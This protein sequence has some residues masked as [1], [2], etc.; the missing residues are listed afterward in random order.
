MIQ[1]DASKNLTDLQ[2]LEIVARYING[3]LEQQQRLEENNKR[4]NDYTERL[5]KLNNLKTV[6]QQKGNPSLNEK[7]GMNPETKLGKQILY[8]IDNV[9]ELCSDKIEAYT[10]SNDARIE[11]DTWLV[12][13]VF[14]GVYEYFSKNKANLPRDI[15][16]R[17][18][19]NLENKITSMKARLSKKLYFKY[20]DFDDDR[21]GL[22]WDKL[23]R[24]LPNSIYASHRLCQMFSRS[25][26]CGKEKQPFEDI[27]N[28]LIVAFN[29]FNWIQTRE[30]GI[31]SQKFIE[32]MI[33]VFIEYCPPI[34]IKA[35]L[36]YTTHAISNELG[37]LKKSNDKNEKSL[38]TA[39]PQAT[40]WFPQALIEKAYQENK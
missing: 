29:L 34:A 12:V 25:G 9:N 40:G 20:N 7:Y 8:I 19:V 27:D 10:E 35:Y 21:L 4:I 32:S 36:A 13:S 24:F 6:L 38:H 2:K 26:N 16:N 22:S 31:E 11:I 33:E 39:I 5:A 30:D 3:L 15:V 14:F 17:D 37:R 18:L 28:W 1:E 23:K